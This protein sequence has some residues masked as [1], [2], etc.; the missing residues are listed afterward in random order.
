MEDLEK[1]IL[2][3]IPVNEEHKKFLEERAASGDKNCC[4]RYVDGKEVTKADIEQAN[5]IIGN[6]DPSLIAGAKKLDEAGAGEG[7]RKV[8]CLK[9]LKKRRRCCKIKLC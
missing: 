9:K 5:V 6:V 3:V 8:L 7:R 2:V 1:N 4:V